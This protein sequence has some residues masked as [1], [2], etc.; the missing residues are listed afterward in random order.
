ML[1]V[2]VGVGHQDDLVVAQPVDVE[3]LVDAGAERGDDRLDL[4]VLQDPVD[5]RLLDVQDLSADRQDRL[6]PRVAA[7]LGR[8][9]G[10][11]ALD[12][13]QLALARLGGLA[14]GELAGQAAAT[15]ES[16]AGAGASRALRAASRAD[17]G[18]CALR[19]ISLPSVGSARTTCRAAR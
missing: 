15:H 3:V 7:L 9:A 17:R 16:L 11:V 18:L 6:H 8:A 12:D 4:L 19:A 14:V 2:D 10:G 5:A 13:E 1:A